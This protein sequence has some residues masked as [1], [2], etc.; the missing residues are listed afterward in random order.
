L[1]DAKEKKEDLT[2]CDKSL[3]SLED[4]NKKLR[5]YI[6]DNIKC[7]LDGKKVNPAVLYSSYEIT[8]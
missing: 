5:Q 6:E 7:D 3:K 8:T 2:K 1:N 4:T